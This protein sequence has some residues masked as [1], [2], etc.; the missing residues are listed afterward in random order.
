MIV[1]LVIV[2]FMIV[3]FMIALLTVVLLT[4]VLLMIAAPMTALLFPGRGG[5]HV[6]VQQR[7][8]GPVKRAVP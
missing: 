4:A 1:L 5:Q 8:Q 7:D 6:R 2:P 3:L